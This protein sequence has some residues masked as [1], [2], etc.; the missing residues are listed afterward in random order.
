M[1]KLLL[2]VVILSP[3]V[4]L[5]SPV[6]LKCDVTQTYTFVPSE[7][8]LLPLDF[9]LD[10]SV[11]EE[12]KSVTYTMGE[13]DS[14]LGRISHTTVGFFTANVITFEWRTDEDFDAIVTRYSLD[15]TTLNLTIVTRSGLRVID[16]AEG[17]CNIVQNSNR[18][19]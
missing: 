5:G 15:R 2:L 12:R 1:E 4:V 14:F 9:V 18:Q 8:E 13:D 6:Y 17:R 10:L 16:R 19:I 11:D 3:S 7:Q